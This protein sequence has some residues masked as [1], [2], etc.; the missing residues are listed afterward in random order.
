M[1]VLTRWNNFYIS[2]CLKFFHR[3]QF[4]AVFKMKFC[5]ISILGGIQDREPLKV[6]VYPSAVHDH[7]GEKQQ[8]C[9]FP[10][11]VRVVQLFPDL[12]HD[13][14][15]STW[16]GLFYE[17]FLLHCLSSSFICILIGV[18]IMPYRSLTLQRFF[19]VQNSK[20]RKETEK[21][22]R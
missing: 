12:S 22:K 5:R 21:S 13:D 17:Y 2:Y 14:S 19:L 11:I 20:R 15:L 4:T 6:H 18:T 9:P 8:N 7:I 10:R 3:F 16:N 1:D